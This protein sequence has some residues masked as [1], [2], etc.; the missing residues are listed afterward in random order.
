MSRFG[1]SNKS[2]KLILDI[3]IEILYEALTRV[4]YQLQVIHFVVGT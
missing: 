4:V 3:Q 2:K 1:G